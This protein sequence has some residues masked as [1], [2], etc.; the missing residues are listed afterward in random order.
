MSE[1]TL[2]HVFEPFFTTKRGQGTGLGLS[3]TYGIVKRLGG[4]IQIKSVEGEGTSL[5]VY[6]PGTPPEQWEISNGRLESAPGR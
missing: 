6:L 3:I 2:R 4:D 5:T 1:D